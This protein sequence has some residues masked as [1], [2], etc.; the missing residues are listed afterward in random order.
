MAVW[1]TVNIGGYNIA[2]QA[3]IAADNVANEPLSSNFNGVLGLALPGNSLIAQRLTPTTTDAPDGAAIASNLFSITPI[4]TAPGVRFLSLALERP[5]SSKVPSV[6]GIGRH[7]AD[8]VPDPSK[9]EYAA[10][11]PSGNAGA[12]WWQASVQAITV[13]DNGVRKPVTLLPSSSGLRTPTAILDSGVPLIITSTAIANGIYGA[14]GVGPAEDGNYYLPCDTPINISIK[15][16]GRNEI[17]L[18]PLD[19]SYYPPNDANSEICIGAIQTPVQFPGLVLTATDIILGV[20]FLRSTYMVMAYDQPAEDGTFPA[21]SLA[22][23]SLEGVRPRLGLLNLTDPA[24]AADEFHQVRVLKQPIGRQNTPTQPH[25]KGISVGV[26][27]L[28][29]LL[30]FFGLCFALFGL[31]WLIMRRRYARQ[32]AATGA[33]EH[34]EGKDGYVIGELGYGLAP[35]KT[36]SASDG[37]SEDELRRRR[38]EA[39]KRRQLDSTYTDDS[40]ITRVDYFGDGQVKADEFGNLKSMDTP[41]T[42]VAT[43]HSPT[44]G[45]FEPWG[46]TLVDG[47]PASHASNA[48]LIPPPPRSARRSDLSPR[49]MHHRSLSGGPGVDVPLLGHHRAGSDADARDPDAQEIEIP[50]ELGGRAPDSPRSMAGVGTASRS[51][52]V[53]GMSP[54]PLPSPSLR[55]DSPRH[56]RGPS[57]DSVHGRSSLSSPPVSAPPPAVLDT[58]RN[59]SRASN[60][61]HEF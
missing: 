16:D 56:A 21:N 29:A 53:S 17:F 61:G 58:S 5:G 30:A 35:M 49:S 33:F 25:S 11:I 19:L 14:M 26:I 50:P 36:K 59:D 32:Q 42:L 9:I 52:R 40:A 28:I 20:P 38:Y 6:L 7:P 41:D 10:I 4:S 8:L 24:V 39:Y 44:R 12:L 2:N 47:R 1:D 60:L 48:T 22:L 13:H 23:N 45:Y 55:A 34:G 37:P 46:D 3:L 31:R 18:H 43:P 54:S 57:Y 15:L 27:V 51:R